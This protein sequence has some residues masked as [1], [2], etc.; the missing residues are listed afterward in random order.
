M[1]RLMFMSEE[2]TLRDGNW[3]CKNKDLLPFLDMYTKLADI[4]DPSHYGDDDLKI[5]KQIVEDKTG[6][7]IEYLPPA[8]DPGAVY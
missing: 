2:C 5:V 4:R 6:T 8:S 3:E 7:F 1:V